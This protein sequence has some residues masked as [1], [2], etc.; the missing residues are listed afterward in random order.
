MAVA[1]ACGAPTDIDEAAAFARARSSRH[2]KTSMLQNVEAGRRM[3][4]DSHRRR[5]AR[6]AA[7]PA[8]RSTDAVLH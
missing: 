8:H 3:E 4:I 2:H 7:A 6:V 1:R 5:A